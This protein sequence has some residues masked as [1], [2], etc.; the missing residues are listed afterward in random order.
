L[1]KAKGKSN[2]A[3]K[4]SRE[5]DW[6]NLLLYSLIALLFYLFLKSRGFVP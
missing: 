1:K 3:K 5:I 2:M 6:G 4:K